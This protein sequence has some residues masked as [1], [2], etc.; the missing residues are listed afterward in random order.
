MT[1]WLILAL[2][3][4][5][6]FLVDFVWQTEKMVIEKGQYGKW[7]GIHHSGLQGICTYVILM[8]FINT[9]ACIILAVVDFFIHY[10]VDWAKMNITR[11]LTIKD[12]MYW[13][14][15]GFDQLI[16]ALTYIGI[17]IVV[18]FLLTDYI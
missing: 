2:L 3:F 5:K 14:W 15:L 12:K 1:T 16:H 8:H 9:Q 11:N 4:I 7:G 10:H 17:G 13:F 18:S 6:H